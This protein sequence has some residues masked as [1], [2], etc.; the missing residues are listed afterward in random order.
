M[1]CLHVTTVLLA[2]PHRRPRGGRRGGG[3]PLRG[4]GVP[5]HKE[6]DLEAL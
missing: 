3:E 6:Q 5:Q 2:P 4:Q 1:L